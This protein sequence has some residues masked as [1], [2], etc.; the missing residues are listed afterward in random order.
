MEIEFDPPELEAPFPSGEEALRWIRLRRGLG[1]I[2]LLR[3]YDDLLC[4]GSIHGIQRYW[5]QVETAKRVLR[6]FHGRV[7]LADEVGLG[8]TIEAGMVIKEY[9]LRG[10]A[11]RVLILTP[12]NLVEQWQE[13]M[14]GKFD[15]EFVEPG[16]RRTD[17]GFWRTEPLIIA[18]IN[19]AKSERISP[20]VIAAEHDLVVV[21][22]AHHLRNRSTRN[23]QL[24]NSLHRRFL[25]LIS[26]TPVQ[27]NLVELF[28]LLTLLRPGLLKTETE[29]KRKYISRTNPRLPKNRDELRELMTEVMIRNT[30]ALVDVRLPPRHATTVAVDP[31]PEEADVYSKLT[32]LLRTNPGGAIS[33]LDAARLLPLAGSAPFALKEP[34]DA[35][36]DR[37]GPS[38]NPVLEALARV[39]GSSKIRKTVE[40]IQARPGKKILF[41]HSRQSLEHLSRAFEEA[42]ISHALF[43]GG[44]PQA[45][46]DMAIGRFRDA[47]DL[48]LSSESGGEGRNLQFCAAMVNFDLPWNPMRIEQRIGRIHRIGQEKEVFILNLCTRGTVEEKLLR[49]LHEK[50][51]MFELVVGEIDGILGNLADDREF[52]DVILELWLHPGGS[53]EAEKG[54]D[55][56]GERMVQ[57]R[58]EYAETLRFERE[59]FSEDFQV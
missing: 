22:E 46:K 43:H 59:L 33:R 45:G 8:K 19:S 21:D 52:A 11:R 28:N 44:L 5:F 10:L 40:L 1:E 36:K 54:F 49:L 9:I 4:L 48:L 57:A 7:L 6:Q 35:L 2:D 38:L 42:G 26:A 31:D 53:E 3:E 47:V 34:L 16:D 29:F 56:L 24:V 17:P 20:H 30:R 27:N 37:I 15:L 12:P 51:N 18:S 41:A 55:A 32:D 23:W 25:I 14:A 58:G 50:I 13:E 39:H